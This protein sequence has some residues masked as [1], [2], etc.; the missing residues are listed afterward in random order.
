M[1]DEQKIQRP[2]KITLSD[3]T[4]GRMFYGCTRLTTPPPKM[5]N[6]F[7]GNYSCYKMFANTKLYSLPE[8]TPVK[9]EAEAEPSMMDD[10]WE[11]RV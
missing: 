10:G 6:L 3:Y 8:L 7:F 11:V 2:P 5:N 9:Y 1:I 4:F